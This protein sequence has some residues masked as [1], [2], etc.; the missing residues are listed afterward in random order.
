MFVFST[1]SDVIYWESSSWPK[2][3]QEV[4]EY[5]CEGG[6]H[7]DSVSRRFTID[8]K[9]VLLQRSNLQPTHWTPE[10]SADTSPPVVCPGFYQVTI[11][12]KVVA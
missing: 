1:D 5:L 11:L 2:Q 12:G 4:S 9:D 3:K 8:E 7:Q 10:Q 6:L